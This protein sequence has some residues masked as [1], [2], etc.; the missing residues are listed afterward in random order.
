MDGFNRLALRYMGCNHQLGDYFSV[1]V[2]DVPLLGTVSAFE[3]GFES[4]IA[5]AY[6][7]GINDEFLQKALF[8]DPVSLTPFVCNCGDI[9]CWQLHLTQTCI[10]D[11]VTWHGWNNPHRSIDQGWDYSGF[12]VFSFYRAD[13]L[14][15][16]GT[17][18]EQLQR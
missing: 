9:D 16:I 13:Y 3:S 12:P 2:D 17:A 15:E 6:M 8:S 5:G 10:G 4:K 7:D 18:L 14:K 11:I 1:M